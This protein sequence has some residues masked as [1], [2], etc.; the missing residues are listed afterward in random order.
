MSTTSKPVRRGRDYV[1][2]DVCHLPKKPLGRSAPL[3]MA[4]GLCDFEC[5][6]FDVGPQPDYLWPN[7]EDWTVTR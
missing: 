3:E 2:C 5:P 7:E 1:Y 4:N 6:G